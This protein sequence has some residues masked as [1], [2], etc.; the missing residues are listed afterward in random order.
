MSR[1][2]DDPGDLATRLMIEVFQV[3]PRADVRVLGNPVIV[4][5]L[6]PHT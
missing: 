2:D 4:R 5:D 3:S 6:Y 1:Y